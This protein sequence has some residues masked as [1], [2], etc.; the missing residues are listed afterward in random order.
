VAGSD[1]CVGFG[2]GTPHS[3]YLGELYMYELRG[4]QVGQR[5]VHSM[6]PYISQNMGLGK[7]R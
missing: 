7:T 6:D 4:L 2:A 5:G 3:F 1:L